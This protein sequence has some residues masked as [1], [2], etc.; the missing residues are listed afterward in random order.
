MSGHQDEVVSIIN[1]DLMNAVGSI[2]IKAP[3][4]FES[5]E[6]QNSW[7]GL[8]V[9]FYTCQLAVDPWLI[10]DKKNFL[11]SIPVPGRRL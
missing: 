1:G 7:M 8:F 2:K 4:Y 10:S 11:V 6:G 5:A 9:G 3:L